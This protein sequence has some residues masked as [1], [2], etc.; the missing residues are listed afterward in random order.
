MRRAET[1]GCDDERFVYL[2]CRGFFYGIVFK[3]SVWSII[4]H[5]GQILRCRYLV[6]ECTVRGVRQLE[7]K[8][9]RELYTTHQ[10]YHDYHFPLDVY[11]TGPSQFCSTED[12]I[13]WLALWSRYQH[14]TKLMRAVVLCSLHCNT[15]LAAGPNRTNFVDANND[16]LNTLAKYAASVWQP[17]SQGGAC[18][19]AIPH[20]LTRNSTS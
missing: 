18:E 11:S 4:Q 17:W 12:W 19:I 15:A 6:A 7:R 2:Y 3:R 5:D 16:V 1:V 14:L 10:L 9:S 13:V 20:S 8:V